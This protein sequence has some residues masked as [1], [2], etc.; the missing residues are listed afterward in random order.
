MVVHVPIG[1]HV[2]RKDVSGVGQDEVGRFCVVVD[3]SRDVQFVIGRQSKAQK[4]QYSQGEGSHRGDS[5]VIRSIP[6]G[7]KQ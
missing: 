1:G 2:E 5:D 3:T 7:R 6:P 4:G